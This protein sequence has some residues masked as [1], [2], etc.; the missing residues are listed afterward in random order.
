MCGVLGCSAMSSC[1]AVHPLRQRGIQTHTGRLCF[2]L[3]PDVLRHLLALPWP[4][5]IWLYFILCSG[6]QLKV[7]TQAFTAPGCRRILKVDLVFPGRF[8]VS[9]GAKDLIA[10][11]SSLLLI[12]WR[13][14]RK[15]LVLSADMRP[16]LMCSC[17][18]RRPATG[19][20][21]RGC[22]STPGSWNMQRDCPHPCSM[23]GACPLRIVFCPASA[24]TKLHV[25]QLLI[26]YI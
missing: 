8:K 15:G 24:S 26:N 23:H 14:L 3:L 17:Y 18:R 22:C 4:S 11:V 6:C 7:A 21:S 5:L 2:K 13:L 10:K 9:D 1:L 12:G 25:S 20:H 19:S 16:L